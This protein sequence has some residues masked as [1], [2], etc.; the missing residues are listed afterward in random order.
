MLRNLSH[1]FARYIINTVGLEDIGLS[2]VSLQIAGW[3][4]AENFENSVIESA[5][6][7][8]LR[9]LQWFSQS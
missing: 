3:L 4:S 1:D 2:L 8:L 7:I 5:E 6:Q 9:V